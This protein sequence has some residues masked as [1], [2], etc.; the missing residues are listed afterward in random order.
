MAALRKAVLVGL[1]AFVGFIPT[2]AQL[3]YAQTVPLL[4]TELVLPEGEEVSDAE[5]AKVEGELV[6][7]SA[8]VAFKI[9]GGKNCKGG[10]IVDKFDKNSICSRDNGGDHRTKG[11]PSDC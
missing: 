6:L 7:T 3:S 5:L 10:K 9:V 4:Q 1:A 2:F 8:I 11:V